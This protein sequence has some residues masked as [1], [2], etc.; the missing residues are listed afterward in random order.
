MPDSG[1]DHRLE[2]A[3][4]TCVFPL[5]FLTPQTVFGFSELERPNLNLGG[6]GLEFQNPDGVQ[7]LSEFEIDLLA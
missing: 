4:R 5:T 6:P 1:T 7:E 3:L 2:L